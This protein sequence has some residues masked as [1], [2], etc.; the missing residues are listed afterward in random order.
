[1]AVLRG[2]SNIKY[3]L[4]EA[5]LDRERRNNEGQD[6]D[7]PPSTRDPRIHLVV[8]RRVDSTQPNTLLARTESQEK[9]N[10]H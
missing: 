1:M 2:V 5:T 8:S 9:V 3:L 6:V 10:Q 4:L 7:K